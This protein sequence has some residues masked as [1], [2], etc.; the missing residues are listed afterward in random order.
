M[1]LEKVLSLLPD[2][3]LD[4]GDLEGFLASVATA[5]EASSVGFRWP[6]ESSPR[7]L[8]SVGE[9]G[10]AFD[11]V[12]DQQSAVAAGLHAAATFVTDK[13]T[14]RL[15]ARVPIVGR[16][17]A[18]L[19]LEMPA[20]KALT[21]EHHAAATAVARLLPS[22]PLLAKRVGPV[23]DQSRLLQRIADSSVVCGRMAHD[24]DNILTGILGFSDLTMPMLPAGSLPLQY[25]TEVSKVGQRGIVFTQQLHQLSRS[26]QT[27][28]QPSSPANV[29][30]AEEGRLRG[31]LKPELRLAIE[32]AQDLPQVG[33]DG[34][35]LQ[36]VISHVIENAIEASPAGG[37]IR[38]V[39]Q[40][41]EID[42]V[43]AA[44]FL[45]NVSPGPHVELS[46]Q[47]QGTGIKP[48]VRPR[49]FVEPFY[50]TK[51][52]HRGLGLAIIYRIL[53]AHRGGIQIESPGT[54]N[55]GTLVRLALPLPIKRPATR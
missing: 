10:P 43:S 16:P 55:S 28:P 24:F 29:L 4:T 53:H 42:P 38:I 3:F 12:A 41:V 13:P 9:R 47:D 2:M 6:L 36:S 1:N 30:A 51:V 45:G 37:V 44:E 32:V 33:I 21:P 46:I 35:P 54:P 50:T 8:V 52:R 19:W 17:S 31:T 23:I 49:L 5:T 34:G 25:I 20:K 48:E 15:F 27:K 40:A 18:V 39:G 14:P 7:A 11:A 22:A 26:G